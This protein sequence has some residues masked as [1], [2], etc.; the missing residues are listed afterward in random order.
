MPIDAKNRVFKILNSTDWALA[1][2]LG[3]SKT[4]LDEGDGYV[5]L[6]TRE[7]VAETLRLHYANQANTRLLEYDRGTF[8]TALKWEES[9]GGQLFPHLYDTLRLD[10]AHRVWILALDQSGIPQLPPD[11]DP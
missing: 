3:H 8:G 11:L 2:S 6:S 1:Q 10:L 9:R 7:Q 5:H 4:A